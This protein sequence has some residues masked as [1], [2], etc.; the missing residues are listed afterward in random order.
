VLAATRRL[1]LDGGYHALTFEAV[2]QAAGTTRTTLHRWWPTRGALVLEGLTARDG[3]RSVWC[4][5]YP[6]DGATLL[7]SRD[8]RQRIGRVRSC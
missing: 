3:S 7:C 6:L 4:P 1:L 5:A 2:A 8:H